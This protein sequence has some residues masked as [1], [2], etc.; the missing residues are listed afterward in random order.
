MPG[1]GEPARFGFEIAQ[2]PVTLDASVRTGSDYGVSVSTSNITQ[3]A[4]FISTTAVFWGVP[5]EQSHDSARGWSCLVGGHWTQSAGRNL[6]CEPTTQ[7]NPAPFLTMPSSCKLPYVATAEGLSWPTPASPGGVPLPAHT[8][9]LEDAF[10]RSLALTGCNRL[11]FEP[12][13]ESQPDV[14]SASSPTGLTTTVKVPQEVSHSAAGLGSSSVRDISVRFPEGVT[15]NPAGADGL[16]ACS[17]GQV[18][19]TGL[20]ELDPAGEPGVSTAQF[21]PALPNPLEPGLNFCPVPSKIG[22]VKIKVPAIAHPLEGSLYLAAQDANPFNALLAAYI[23]AEDEESGV[24]VK[25]P[26]RIALDPVTGQLTATFENSPDAPLED[27]EIHLFGG[28]RAPLST[29]THCGTYTTD[30]TFTPWSGTAPVTSSADFKIT[31]GPNKGPCPPAALPFAPS[32]TAGSPNINAGSFSPLMT[33]IGREDGN[34]NINQ[35]QLHFAAGHVRHPRGHPALP[36]SRSERR[37]LRPE[38]SLIGSTIVSVGLGGDPF[39][40]TGGQGL[41]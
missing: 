26:G 9:G 33:T 16:Q 36:R 13:V 28:E 23:V 17:V 12:F 10:G 32:L 21:T 8:Y 38:S 22:T 7:S 14:S 34:Q 19:F 37:H 41:S 3:L 11:S 6:P 25:L 35:V 1:K 39:T 24:L 15:V 27:A 30:A 18:G 2:A 40:V 31:T 5:G 20:G 4:A 29:P